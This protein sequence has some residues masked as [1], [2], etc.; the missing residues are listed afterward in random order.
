MPVNIGITFLVGGILGW[1]L[2]KLLK[3]NPHLE[4]L[5]IATCS[6]GTAFPDIHIAFP[7]PRVDVPSKLEMNCLD[8]GVYR[9][10]GESFADCCSSNLQRERQSLWEQRCLQHCG[11]LLCLILHG[12]MIMSPILLFPFSMIPLHSTV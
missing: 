7:D 4:G 3:P 9:E 2:V 8:C 6:S 5:V 11:A 10:S 1:V 12:G